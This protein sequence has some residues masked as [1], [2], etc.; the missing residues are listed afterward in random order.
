MK[1]I[2]KLEKYINE[3]IGDAKK[4]VECALTHKE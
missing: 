3:E 1:M 4:Y 2:K